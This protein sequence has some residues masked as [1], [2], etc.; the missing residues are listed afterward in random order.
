MIRSLRAVRTAAIFFGVAT[1]A[2]LLGPAAAASPGGNT[3]SGCAQANAHYAP[4]GNGANHS[5]PYDSTCDG[6]ASANGNGGGQA[7]GRPCAG[8]VGRADNKNPHG[9]YPNAASDGNNG[10][11]CDGNSGIA[12]ENPAHTSC[13]PLCDPK[14]DPK[15]L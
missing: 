4:T 11:E 9:Q 15:C 3:A 6:T 10:Y 5:G 7:N 14:V 2:L 13:V 1:A 8:C 12:R